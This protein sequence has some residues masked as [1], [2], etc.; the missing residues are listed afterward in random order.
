VLVIIKEG[1][2]RRYIGFSVKSLKD[3]FF[4][5]KQIIEEIRKKCP[6][7]FEKD[8]KEVGIYLIRYNDGKGIVRCKHTDKETTIKLLK[9]INKISDNK[10]IIETIG[11]SGTI[12][13]LVRKHFK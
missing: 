5:K 2:R 8:C 3:V 13:S 11:T 4:T 9:S 12:K 10:V 1:R 7:F 6:F